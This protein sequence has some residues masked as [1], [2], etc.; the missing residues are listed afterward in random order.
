[1]TPSTT[2]LAAAPAPVQATI[3]TAP[4]AAEGTSYPG[5][6]DN[7]GLEPPESSVA[8]GPEH[9]FQAVDTTF[10]ISDR[11]GTALKTVSMF[12]FF[13]L[14]TTY[15]SAGDVVQSDPRV[16]FD[17]LHQ[18]W[19]AIESRYDCVPGT[20]AT[21]P[22][23]GTGWLDIATSRSA[24]PTGDWASFSIRYAGHPPDST[25][26]GAS[27]DKVAISANVHYLVADAN[28]PL[29]CG[30]G[31]F[32]G[33]EIDVLAWSEL[34]GLG[35]IGIAF[36]Y[37]DFA[38]NSNM[39]NNYVSWRLA[40]QAPE[41][42]ATLHVIGEQLDKTVAYGEITGSAGG[43]QPGTFT[44]IDL[45]G[46]VAPFVTPPAPAQ[47]GSPGTIVNAVNEWPSA[48]TW[49]K[50]RL[51]FLSTHPCDPAGGA[52]ETRDCIRVTELSTTTALG[53]TLRQDFLVADDG[54]DLYSGGIAYAGNGD[55]HVV[56]TRSSSA[57]GA[58]PSSY[59]AH[60]LAKDPIDRLSA[61]QALAP[62]SGTYPGTHWGDF[63]GLAQDPQ[64]PN[65]IWQADQFS[66]GAGYWSTH[67]SQLQTGGNSYVP[68]TP[69]RVLNSR[70]AGVF[71]ANTAR[72]FQVT[73]VAGI[74]A[75]A[76]AVTG[77]LSV[78]GPTASGFVAIT[79]T[80]TATPS[81]AT[82]N[83][84]VGD[85]RA[86]NF[87]IALDANGRL[88][89]VYKA[90][91]G[92][93]VSLIVDV[94]GYFLPGNQRA[95]YR[96]VTPVR[97]MDTR[98][99][100]WRVGSLGKFRAGVPQSL[101]IAGHHGIPVGAVAI[102]GNLTMLGQTKA[103]RMS[104]TTSA[105]TTPATSTIYAPYGDIRVNGLT[106]RLNSS[107]RLSM[108]YSAAAGATTNAIL[109]V[110]GYYLPNTSGLLYYPLNPGHILNTRAGAILSGLSGTFKAGTPRTLDTDGHWGVPVGA[111]AITGNLTVAN[112]TATG[113]VAI[114]LS[115]VAN[116]PITT[117]RFPSSGTRDNGVTAALS[118]AGNI[119]LV[120]KATAGRTT[121][122]IL[123]LSGYFK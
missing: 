59:A 70:T 18:R 86:N 28:A 4:Q 8:V 3:T 78:T 55:L 101:T 108:T 24:D 109:D 56:W 107:G 63:T 61:P 68:I 115:P 16:I 76:T 99:G 73:G 23:V 91:A 13:G 52:T 118:G 88:G 34:A 113:S 85:T 77:N 87:T 102:T 121:N 62:G 111:R 29:G 57:A 103:G 20:N 40:N 112:Q 7:S 81:A 53:P 46:V 51:A 49:Q 79:T 95:T 27:T 93:T 122:L 116:P 74:P 45:S 15:A 92:K 106:A 36:Y 43:G 75:G 47:P 94:T 1:M 90:A 2:P 117:M 22:T 89:A 44:R 60:Q 50:D 104:V 65:A 10:R 35:D 83:F 67:V 21:G 123:E 119:A 37:S 64:V 38:P 9:V 30:P 6:A 26:L 114:T 14:G 41:T 105:V 97:V 84:P 48:A 54:A 120:Y 100:S 80:A 33:T 32:A 82:M 98:S 72:T 110:T 58:F 19:V 12:D 71:R 17:S 66:A 69:V 31:A 11:S 42:K 25:S 39:P 96:T 5:L